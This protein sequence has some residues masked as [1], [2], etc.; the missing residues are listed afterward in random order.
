MKLKAITEDEFMSQVAELAKLRGWKIAHFRPLRTKTGWRTACQFDAQGFP[1]LV[2]VRG[3]NRLVVAELKRSEK[4]KPTDEQR[5]WLAAFSFVPS[6]E[7]FLW[8][9]GCW[10]EIEKVLR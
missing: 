6:V 9:P 3:D 2:M 1:D 10:P 4:E 5:A 7:V 8:H